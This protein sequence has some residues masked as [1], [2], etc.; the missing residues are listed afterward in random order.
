MPR[1]KW[2]HP[3]SQDFNRDPQVREL[4]RQF[5]D[6]MALV[7]IEMLS[8]GSR[9]D[10]RIPGKRDQIAECLSHVSMMNRP[11]LAAER[12]ANAMQFMTDCGWIEEQSGHVLVL[13]HAKYNGSREKDKPQDGIGTPPLIQYSTDNT[14]QKKDKKPSGLF[15]SKSAKRD[16][17]KE[18]LEIVEK[19]NALSGKK[20]RPDSKDVMK[21][22]FARMEAGATVADCLVV[23]EDRWRRW[24]ESEKMFENFNP[25]TLFRKSNFERYLTEAQ[26]AKS[27][28]GEWKP[29]EERIAKR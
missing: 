25:V 21:F 19:I 26:A 20:Y 8:I 15:Y 9:N 1:I 3:V 5:G 18:I 2:W 6:W 17:G 27:G 28:A 4:R 12:I 29:P 23:I 13:N 10:G 7:W 24:G 16:L 14:I 22:L 11:R